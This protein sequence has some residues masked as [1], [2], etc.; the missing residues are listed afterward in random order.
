MGATHAE[1]LVDFALNICSDQGDVFAIPGKP[2][3]SA[4]M[5][6]L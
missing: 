3:S 6:M 2:L 1:S 5:R 4:I